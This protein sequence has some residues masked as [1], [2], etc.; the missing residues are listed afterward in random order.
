MYTFSFFIAWDAKYASQYSLPISVKQGSNSNQFSE[1]CSVAYG[2][3]F[4]RELGLFVSV[5]HKNSCL[6][7][8]ECSI[9][10]TMSKGS[11][12]SLCTRVLKREMEVEVLTKKKTVFVSRKGLPL[13][14]QMEFGYFH[15]QP[16]FYSDLK[17]FPFCLD[18][19]QVNV[20]NDN[21]KQRALSYWPFPH[22]F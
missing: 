20:Y 21:Q 17:F 12:C 2:L 22:F 1:I 4:T 6:K 19:D 7:A 14:H 13:K 11:W 10:K 15:C 5:F 9:T 16:I 18:H 3:C 8:R